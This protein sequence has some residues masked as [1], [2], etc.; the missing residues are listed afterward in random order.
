MRRLVLHNRRP[1]L[2]ALGALAPLMLI[3]LVNLP[4]KL[5]AFFPQESS[6]HE[7]I[8]RLPHV[9]LWAWER[10]ENFAFI[11]P[12]ETGVAY[13]ARTIYLRGER[14][15]VRPRLQPLAV[16]P[17]TSLTVVARIES[18]RRVPPLRTT[19]QLAAAADAVAELG[20]A[21]GVAAVQI[22]FDAGVSER[23]FYRTLLINVRRQLPDA[24]ALTI[25][26]LAS[27]CTHDD[28]LTG[29][30]IDEAVPMLFRM[31]ADRQQISNFLGTGNQFGPAVCHTSAG[32][33]I[34]EAIPMLSHSISRFY[35]FA[36]RAWTERDARIAVEK[37]RHEK[38]I[39]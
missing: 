8:T 22:D 19:A 18:D 9:I 37:F 11:N 28:W 35:I 26:A 31:G 5:D 13:L 29:L 12:R 20:R 27:W 24:V 23:E 7:R 16:P 36:P 1:R 15:F 32:I 4:T 38:E 25:T 2:I 34:D 17:N 10:P 3:F 21:N 33:S 14:V 6:D 30:P 39:H